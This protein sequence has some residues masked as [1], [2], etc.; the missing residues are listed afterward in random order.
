ML[1]PAR[2]RVLVRDLGRELATQ[3]DD[4][5]AFS[6]ALAARSPPLARGIR[7]ELE[8]SRAELELELEPLD[9]AQEGELARRL[10]DAERD[11]RGG[12]TGA[13]SALPPLRPWLAPA[14]FARRLRPRLLRA[15]LRHRSSLEEILERVERDAALSRLAAHAAVARADDALSLL[16]MIAA[17]GRARP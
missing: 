8:A 1:S 5:E 17:L 15:V 10:A 2:A 6:E 11:V 9:A 14:S 3:T 16:A 12:L 7:A 4:Y 13:L